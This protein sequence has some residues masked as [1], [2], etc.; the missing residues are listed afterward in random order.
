MSMNKSYR[1]VKDTEESDDGIEYEVTSRGSPGI[2]TRAVRAPLLQAKSSISTRLSNADRFTFEIDEPIETDLQTTSVQSSEMLGTASFSSSEDENA[3]YWEQERIKRGHVNPISSTKS[4]HASTIETAPNH[5]PEVMIP[6]P[7]SSMIIPADQAFQSLELQ[8]SLYHKS[9]ADN[10]EKTRSSII[11]Q[12]SGLEKEHIDM[13][14]ALDASKEQS[15]FCQS[16]IDHVKKWGQFNA[17]ILSIIQEHGNDDNWIS[18]IRA[19]LYNQDPSLFPFL[20]WSYT[21]QPFILSR[22]YSSFKSI[23][24]LYLLPQLLLPHIRLDMMLYKYDHLA[25]L[26]WYHAIQ[27]LRDPT[28]S[29]TDW[30]LFIEKITSHIPL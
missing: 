2:P 14:N 20:D 13:A 1:R 22:N 29:D 16:L 12:L 11:S 28:I 4:Q 30:G 7:K 21:F 18:S 24:L 5:V 6:Y 17:K 8:L 26:P 9:S 23:D 25:S 10:L 15:I 27:S 19:H 3:I